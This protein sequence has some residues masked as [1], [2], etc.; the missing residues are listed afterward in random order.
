MGGCWGR[1]SLSVWRSGKRMCVE[2][3]GEVEGEKE[4]HQT[5]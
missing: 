4:N 2:K 3:K 1:G 5:D